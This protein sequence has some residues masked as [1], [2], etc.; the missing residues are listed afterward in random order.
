MLSSIE[1]RKSLCSSNLN[2][3]E[4]VCSGCFYISGSIRKI[5]SFRLKRHTHR[6]THSDYMSI[7]NHFSYSCLS[8]AAFFFQNHICRVQRVFEVSK[9]P[10]FN[11]NDTL[12]Q[13]D[14]PCLT[15]FHTLIQWGES[16]LSHWDHSGSEKSCAIRHQG[17]TSF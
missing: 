5:S 9:E 16:F 8:K 7:M 6:H 10:H 2:W 11:I 12:V 13:C 14:S 1:L 4:T 3:M 15:S 17:N